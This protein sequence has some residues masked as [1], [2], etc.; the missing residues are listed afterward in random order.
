M[1]GS[2]VRRYCLTGCGSFL[3]KSCRARARRWETAFNALDAG[4]Y[5]GVW[6]AVSPAVAV[7]AAIDVG[8]DL[9]FRLATN[10]GPPVQS[11]PVNL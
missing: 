3:S 1:A 9:L 7:G 5:A 8:F 11:P 4:D 6:L 2:P 10:S